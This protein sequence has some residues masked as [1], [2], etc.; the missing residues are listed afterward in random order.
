[1][2]IILTSWGS[3]S[4]EG[5]MPREMTQ[6]VPH[7]KAMMNAFDTNSKTKNRIKTIKNGPVPWSREDRLF[8]RRQSNILYNAMMHP[9]IPYACRGLVWYQGES[10]TQTMHGKKNHNAGMLQYDETLKEWI[11]TYRKSWNNDAMHFM[12]VMLPGFGKTLGSEGTMVDIPPNSQPIPKPD[13]AINGENPNAQSWAWMRASQLKALDLPNT[14][15]VNTIDL[16]DFKDVHPKDKLPIGQRAALLAMDEISKSATKS[17]GAIFKE[18]K[19]EGNTL[20]VYFDH[21]KTLKTKDGKDPTGFWLADDS[22]NWFRAD[23]KIKGKTVVLQSSQLSNP[24]YIRYAFSAKP[25]VNLVN[26]MDLPVYPFR[27]DSFQP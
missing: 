1:V 4:I 16:G 15:V 11:K 25:E 13:P 8:V 14:S 12:I 22:E 21:A 7:F 23:A 6:T 10:N 18:T 9:L 3:S 5:W 20:V 17:G 24:K 19:I 2:G 27:T 26:E